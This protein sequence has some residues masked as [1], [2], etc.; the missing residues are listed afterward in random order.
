MRWLLALLLLMLPL[1]APAQQPLHDPQPLQFRNDAEERRFHD[2]AAQLRC[3]QCQNQSLADSNAQ[4]AQDLRREV[5]QLMQQG[6][7]DAQIKQFLVARY[8]EFVLYQP[9]LQPGTW[10][11]WGGPLLVLGAGALVVLGIVRRR[12]R[13]VGAAAAGKA[14]EGD[15]W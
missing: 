12:G 2:L 9:P 3:V 4:I 7:D 14:D 11:L 13:S 10:L 8:G 5:L 6:H 15:G 1:A